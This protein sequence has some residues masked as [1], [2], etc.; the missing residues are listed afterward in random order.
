VGALA[1]WTLNGAPVTTAP[2]NQGSP[3]I[4]PDGSG[5]VIMIWEDQRTGTDF[6]VYAQRMDGSGKV[7]W[8]TDGVS[9]STAPNDQRAPNLIGSSQGGAIATWQDDQGG[10][11]FDIKAQLLNGWGNALWT[12]NGVP[13][14]AAADNQLQPVIASDGQD[15]AIVAW[16]DYRSIDSDIIAQRVDANGTVLWTAD[17]VPISTAGDD[18][19]APAL[20]PDGLGGAIITWQ[21]YRSGTSFDI[22]VQRVDASGNTL[23]EAGGIPLSTAPNDQLSPKIVSDD[24]GGAVVAW[25]DNQS[26]TTLE[27]YAQR[28]DATGTVSWALNGVALTAS[29]R[30]QLSPTL[31]SD[32]LGGAVVA[33]YEYQSGANYDVYAQRVSASGVLL[34]TSDG[35]V[36]SAAGGLQ[37]SPTIVTDA[38]NGAV[39]AWDDNRSGTNFDIYSQR[40]DSSG[41]A[42]WTLDGTGVSMAAGDQTRAVIAP[43]MTSAIIAWEDRRNGLTS[44]IYAQQAGMST[45]GIEMPFDSG[46]LL[47][48]NQPNPFTRSTE[49][50][51]QLSESSR[52][53]LC[54]ATSAGR[55]V[56]KQQWS[57]L[58]PGWWAIPFDGHDCYGRALSSGVYL[59]RVSAAGMMTGTASVHTRKMVRLR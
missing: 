10:T 39:V 43:G 35:A 23:W 4:T 53:N 17:G 12:V 46:T 36:A 27:I 18:Q 19:L 7:L 13:L 52:V 14:S 45:V 20:I 6:D 30:L 41:V 42:L 28:I 50:R 26:G 8:T 21:D 25:Y 58:S 40:I 55:L 54:V 9:L 47:V 48:S 32:G 29:T 16:E 57:E 38:Q 44:D 15:G 22:Y 51:F 11:G 34:W 49:I 2:N 3:R 5:G 33:W 59:Y 31:A 24:Q 37:F 56:Y 1:D